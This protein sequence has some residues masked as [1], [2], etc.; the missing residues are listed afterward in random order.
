MGTW[1]SVEPSISFDLMWVILQV[2]ATKDGRYIQTDVT[3]PRSID[4]CDDSVTSLELPGWD[5]HDT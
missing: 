1:M 5:I 4:R 2:G 3:M